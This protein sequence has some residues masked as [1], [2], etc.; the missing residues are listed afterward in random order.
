MQRKGVALVGSRG[1]PAKYGGGE[2]FVEELSKSLIS[3][4]N[5]F[6]S[7]QSNRFEEE[8]FEGIKLIK[9]PL[10]YISNIEIPYLN[11]II[12]TLYLIKKYKNSISLVYY[13]SPGGGIAAPLCKKFGIKTL[14]NADGIE[15]KRIDKRIQFIPFYK[16]PIYILAK[17]LLFLSEIMACKLPDIT[18]ADARNIKKHLQRVHRVKKVIFIP[19]GSRKLIN[20][21]LTEKDELNV[22]NRFQL[23]KNEYYLTVARIVAENNIHIE[24]EGFIKSGSKKKLVIVGN[25]NKKDSYTNYLLGLKKENNNIIFLDPIYDKKELGIIRKNCYAY[26]HSYEIGGTNPSLLEQM[27]FIKPIIAYD[28][29]FH[30]EILKKG[31]IF[32]S[33]TNELS[34]KI[35]DLEFGVKLKQNYGYIYNKRIIEEYNWKKVVSKYKVL[36]EKLINE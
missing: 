27:A 3:D 28:V 22:L 34:K 20:S 29:S 13:I 4:Y 26:I 10:I 18:I 17:F 14:V 12:P 7:C 8:V 25:F 16:K 15:W 24:I 9:F 23:N 6:V 33:D 21:T 2:T 11:H 30:R 31:G 32:F 35:N 5:V 1:I 19:Y 36:I